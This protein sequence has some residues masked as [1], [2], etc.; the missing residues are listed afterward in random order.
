MPGGID[1]VLLVL[2]KQGKLN[3]ITQKRICAAMNVYV[4]GPFIIISANTLYIALLYGNTTVPI[5]VGIFMTIISMFNSLYYTKRAVA[6]HAVSHAMSAFEEI[7][8]VA[9]KMPRTFVE[10]TK[11]SAMMS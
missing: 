8:G 7:T 4:R 10:M 9:L 5:S 11:P 6:N 1:Y 2:V 3:T